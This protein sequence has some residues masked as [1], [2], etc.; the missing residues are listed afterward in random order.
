MKFLPREQNSSRTGLSRKVFDEG[1]FLYREP[2]G[3]GK[4]QRRQVVMML[5]LFDVLLQMLHDSVTAGTYGV[6]G[7][8]AC[9]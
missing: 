1:G 8:F 3:S 6:L 5:S 4:C 7:T 9:A 2:V